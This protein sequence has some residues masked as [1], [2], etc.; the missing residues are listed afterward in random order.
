MKT[1]PKPI[2]LERMK[3][4]SGSNLGSIGECSARLF[5]MEEIAAM[6]QSPEGAALLPV[7]TEAANAKETT[8]GTAVHDRLSKLTNI[9]FDRLSKPQYAIPDFYFDLIEGHDAADY[10]AF[11][12]AVQRDV[13]I[14]EWIRRVNAANP[15]NPLVAF[16]AVHVD[17][18]RF[19][20]QLEDIRITAMPDIAI[21]ARHRNGEA[22]SLV[23]DFKSG[24]GYSK[25]KTTY[26]RLNGHTEQ[27]AALAIFV[28][29]SRT[30][31]LSVDTGL[32]TPDTIK[33]GVLTGFS[34]EIPAAPL[35]HFDKARLDKAEAAL[36]SMVRTAKAV[37]AEINAAP[38]EK[39]GEL[40]ES[41]AKVSDG[42]TY[43]PA[44]GSCPKLRKTLEARADQ[45]IAAAAS[46][47]AFGESKAVSAIALKLGEAALKAKETKSA[48][49]KEE[50]LAQ[51]EHYISGIQELSPAEKSDVI[52][53]MAILASTNGAFDLGGVARKFNEFQDILL[54]HEATEKKAKVQGTLASIS[55]TPA[56]EAELTG[57]V[58]VPDLFSHC[59]ASK[60]EAPA[61]GL[62][63]GK[64]MSDAILEAS[65]AG[66]L[67]PA[68]E[69][70]ISRMTS[71]TRL[72]EFRSELTAA[73]AAA[74]SALKA[75]NGTDRDREILAALKGVAPAVIAKR[76]EY[77][78]AVAANAERFAEFA[79]GTED[80]SA[81][82]EEINAVRIHSLKTG[83]SAD[84]D[85]GARFAAS[86]RAIAKVR[87]LSETN[88][89]DTLAYANKALVAAGRD[90]AIKLHELFDVRSYEPKPYVYGHIK[91]E[92]AEVLQ[93]DPDE[94]SATI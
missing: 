37:S 83:F 31:T 61:N 64:P 14:S 21:I 40:F 16:E 51:V 19:E 7:Y 38:E 65:R 48:S 58:G 34:N 73:G 71:P 3:R 63:A 13:T 76:D 81:V 59:R 33:K 47:E 20:G 18:R 57:G 2:D 89:A 72:A 67:L 84:A 9:D 28:S 22:S 17:D 92:V 70:H 74:S 15:G 32:I 93:R 87:E 80:I 42:C 79:T 8:T 23:L 29:Q 4:P 43:C 5:A 26:Q 24:R 68:I 66:N 90:G 39:K 45:A 49:V 91:A 50:A 53:D 1:A 41:R 46:I 88:G 86:E 30:N 82:L 36:A 56:K 11:Q 44:I 60:G 85:A 69:A 27:E 52:R 35:S 75:G 55:Y 78:R 54:R 6:L 94:I 25:P 62:P 12:A 77:D 10:F